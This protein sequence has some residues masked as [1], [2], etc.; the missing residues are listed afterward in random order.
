MLVASAVSIAAYYNAFGA[1]AKAFSPLIALGIGIVL[2][3][4]LAYATK[5]RYYIARTDEMDARLIV[6]GQLSA[7]TL[8][9]TVCADT[10]ERPDMAGCPFHEGAICSL[11]RSLEKDC[12]NACKKTGPVDLGIPA[13]AASQA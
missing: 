9:C 2:S 10:F 4:V 13:V 8:T 5:G 6:D 3:L 11:C 12:Q 1:Y 7:A